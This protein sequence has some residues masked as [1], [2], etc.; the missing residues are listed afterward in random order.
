MPHCFVTYT[1]EIRNLS[2]QVIYSE[3]ELGEQK[4]I[5]DKQ[6]ILMGLRDGIKLMHQNEM[7]QF[8]FFPKLIY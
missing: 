5:V 8:L 4:Y 1:Y 6:E 2:N 3:K 7:V